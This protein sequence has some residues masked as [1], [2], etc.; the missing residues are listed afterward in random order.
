MKIM[1]AGVGKVGKNLTRKLAAEGYD[2]TVVDEAPEVLEAVV[3]DFDVMAVPGNC[4]SVEV[5]K[6]AG[7]EEMDLLIAVSGADEV[8]LLTCLTAHHLNP[9]LHTIAR[10][11]NP[12]YAD[13]AYDMSDL[14]ALSLV[15]NPEKQAAVE[16]ERLLKYPGFLKRDTFAKGRVVIAELR[17]EEKSLLD[18]CALS[19]LSSVARCKVLVCVV[20]RNG[21][22]VTPD[23][24]FVLKAGD[25]VFVTAPTNDLALL[26]KN[27]GMVTRRVDRAMICGGGRISYY[28][29]QQ[30]LKGGMR[31]TIVENNRDR[32]RWLTEH[33]PKADVIQGDAMSQ[34][35]LD[36]EG[37]EHTDALV[38]LTGLDELNIMVSLYGEARGVPQVI[39]KLGRNFSPQ[40][41]SKLSLGS[42]IDPKDLSSNIIVRYVRALKNQTGAAVSV[43]TIADG[44]VEA[45]EFRIDGTAAHC[46]EPLKKLKLKKNVLIVSIAHNDHTEIPDGNS[47]FHQGDT[48]VVVTGEG[49]SLTRF[50]DIFEG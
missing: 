3:N 48:V 6:N 36:R 41:L 45:E 5:L 9:R 49:R 17:V 21:T 47:C 14:F 32:C 22:A 13:Q 39:T 28:L 38:A 27:L 42:I 24:S 16:I 19:R 34:S 30:L 4:A 33:L 26:L 29:A 23:G 1:I 31:V 15:V 50:N 7:V 2:I 11:R 46:G 10:I 37:I 12:D 18:G 35:L 40:I 43:H 8:N 44:Q 25:R 20:L